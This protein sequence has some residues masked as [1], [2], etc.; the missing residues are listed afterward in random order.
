MSYSRWGASTW[1][2]F[3]NSTS[4]HKEG[5]LFSLWYSLESKHIKDWKYSELL[6]LTVPDIQRYY[7]CN[8]NEAEEAMMYVKRF[9]N[10]VD[11]DFKES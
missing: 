11:S 3:Y 7:D 10:D 1:Y 2:S 6:E 4:E 9:I 8:L 5:Q